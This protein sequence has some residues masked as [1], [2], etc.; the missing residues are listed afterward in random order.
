MFA[1][2]WLP[3]LDNVSLL[4]Y[5]ILNVVFKVLVIYFFIFNSRLVLNLLL[6]LLFIYKIIHI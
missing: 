6:L 1:I 5:P 3:V 2:N 4:N